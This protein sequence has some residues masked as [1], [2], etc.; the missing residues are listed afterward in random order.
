MNEF[1]T[2]RR[3][4][5]LESKVAA[6]EKVVNLIAE[7]LRQIEDGRFNVDLEDTLQAVKELHEIGEPKPETKG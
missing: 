1:L 2:H 3:I 4:A 7:C 5:F 6:L